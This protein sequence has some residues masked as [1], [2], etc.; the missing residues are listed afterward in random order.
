M[1]T[2]DTWREW[3]EKCALALCSEDTQRLLPRFV[4]VK[5]SHFVEAC[6]RT[7][8]VESAS[9]LIPSVGESWHRFETHFQLHGL[10]GGKT[11]KDWLFTRTE[12]MGCVT[13]KSVERGAS[14][15]LR[16][17][18][19]EYL[20]WEYSSRRMVSMGG[21]PDGNAADGGSLSLEE[22][23]P[24]PLDTT[25]E[26][27]GRELEELARADS[28]AAVARLD[29]R[30]KIA[31]L[32]HEAG[33]SLAH[34]EALKAAGCG[35]NALNIAFHNALTGIAAYAREQ[36]PREDSAVHASLACSMYRQ[37]RQIIFSWGKSENGCAQLF[38]LIEAQHD[39]F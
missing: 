3:E 8:N 37:V 2:F 10:P 31:L 26:V 7:T 22:L 15:L 13:Q 1:Q 11:Y 27:E 38:M 32:V 24:G 9:G 30:E 34:P 12:E 36:H 39:G 28:A 18:V 4:H 25:R 16:D 19:R 29:W 6:V 17:V 35:R 14:L 5:F 20:R 33:V 21:S 23:L